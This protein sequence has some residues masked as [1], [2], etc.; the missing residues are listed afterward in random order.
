MEVDQKAFAAN[1]ASYYIF[2]KDVCV[3]VCVCVC[4]R[5]CMCVRVCVC[6][7]ACVRARVCVYVSVCTCVRAC[8]CSAIDITIVIISIITSMVIIVTRICITF[9]LSVEFYSFCGRHFLREPTRRII[10][11]AGNC[12]QANRHTDTYINGHKCTHAPTPLQYEHCTQ[13]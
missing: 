4:V 12:T 2:Y 13:E 8:V 5:V 9:S 10:Q 3:C 7:R 1:A 6:V 11:S